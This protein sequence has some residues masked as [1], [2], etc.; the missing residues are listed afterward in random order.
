HM[1]RGIWPNVPEDEVPITHVTNGVHARS[2]LSGDLVYLLDRYL[3]SRWQNNPADQSVWQAVNEV[4][5]EELWRVH[6]R[7]R[8]KLIVWARRELRR[9]LEAR[10]TNPDHVRAACE[11]LNPN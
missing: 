10:G 6:E 7:R 2:W 1:W 9:Q 8:Q 4:P 5:D 11:A 3:G